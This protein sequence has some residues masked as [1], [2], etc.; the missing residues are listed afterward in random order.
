MSVRL[1]IG[2]PLIAGMGPC[3][4]CQ[5]GYIQVVACGE[6]TRNGGPGH[7]ATEIPLYVCGACEGKLTLLLADALRSPVRPYVAA[8]LPH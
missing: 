1:R 7:E 5:R 2:G 6:L 3:F 4:M 8:G